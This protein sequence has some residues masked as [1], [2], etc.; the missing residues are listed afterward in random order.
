MSDDPWT[1]VDKW[2]QRFDTF[3]VE[4]SRH[5]TGDDNKWCIYLYVYKTSPLHALITTDDWWQDCLNE[6]PLH[7]GVSFF[8]RMNACIKIGCDYNHLH[9]D[10]CLQWATRE[11]A[12]R[13]FLDAETLITY[14]KEKY[15]G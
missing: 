7:C 4:I 1:K 6:L 8:E 13:V 10:H 11:D 15:N 2:R 9:D 12:L 14:M 5:S 3:C